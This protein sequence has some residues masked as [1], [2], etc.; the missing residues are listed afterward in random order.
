MD[1]AALVR[2]CL[3]GQSHAFGLLVERYQKPLFNTAFRML[4][5]ATEAED[6]TQTAFLKAYEHLAS[7]DPSYQFFSWIYRITVNETLN[8]IKARRR[9]LRLNGEIGY[10]ET[11]SDEEEMAFEAN[12][13]LDRAFVHLSPEER[14]LLLLKH[15]EGFTYEE[16]GFVFDI[17][18]KLVKSRL[19]TARQRLKDVL[20]SQS[21]S[22]RT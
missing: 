11:G 9:E 8:Y 7:Y 3:N 14:A 10:E 18:V 4:K 6:I 5:D 15:V 21:V 20:V 2:Q 19:Y 13:R 17:S 12:D 22:R 16:I 1:D